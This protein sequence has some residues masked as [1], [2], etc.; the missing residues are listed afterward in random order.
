M[1]NQLT[2]TSYCKTCSQ[3][4]IEKVIEQIDNMHHNLKSYHELPLKIMKYN[5]NKFECTFIRY[6]PKGRPYNG[7]LREVR[8]ISSKE[9]EEYK[10]T[11]LKINAGWEEVKTELLYI[12]Q[13]ECHFYTVFHK[14][15][16]TTGRISEQPLETENLNKLE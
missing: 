5:T 12:G 4:I 8:Q 3:E 14:N 2:S 10:K 7:Y 13:T 1:K 6:E 16:Q 9:Y 15:G 11:I